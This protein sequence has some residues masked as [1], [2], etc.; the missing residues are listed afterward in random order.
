[1]R[2]KVAAI[3]TVALLA[4]AAGSAG[5]QN[6]VG[7]NRI[8]VPAGTDVRLTVPFNQALEGTFAVATKT[9]STVTVADTLVA[10]KYNNV[11]TAAYYVRFTSGNAS[12]LWTTITSNDVNGFTLADANVM[13]LV[14]VGDSFRVYKHHTL[15]SLF[16]K[17]M[18]D[19]S[20]TNSTKVLIYANNIAAMA[21]NK[22][23]AKTA[24]Y[25]TAGGGM[26]S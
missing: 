9:G 10:G 5:A 18:Y 2:N 15:S 17:G 13:N 1:M 21:Q 23:A 11:A 7:Y 20:Y 4:L 16:P 8:T 22:P 3:A 14:S 6:V 26:W 19:V 25:T 24:S 12:G